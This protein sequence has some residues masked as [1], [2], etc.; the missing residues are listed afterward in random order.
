MGANIFKKGTGQATDMIQ[1]VG[2]FARRENLIA[3][4]K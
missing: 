2:I 3:A 1:R 4:E